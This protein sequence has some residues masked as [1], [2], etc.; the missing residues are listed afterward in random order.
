MGSA[1]A[2]NK[3]ETST[4]HNSNSKIFYQI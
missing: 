3:Q 4:L 1:E 2:G